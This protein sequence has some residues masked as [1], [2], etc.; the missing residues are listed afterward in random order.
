MPSGNA[1]PFVAGLAEHLLTSTAGASRVSAFGNARTS[2][3]SGRTKCAPVGLCHYLQFVDARWQFFNFSRNGRRPRA[4][5]CNIGMT[6][7]SSASHIAGGKRIAP[8]RGTASG[9]FK[10][11]RSS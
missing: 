9:V 7:A 1:A 3:V 6:Y 5:Y 8:R 11:R 2:S 4:L 10:D